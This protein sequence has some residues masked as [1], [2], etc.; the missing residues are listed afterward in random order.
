MSTW[1]VKLNRRKVV[2]TVKKVLQSWPDYS[3]GL[4]GMEILDTKGR[5]HALSSI[6]FPSYEWEKIGEGAKIE[7]TLAESL[8]NPRVISTRFISE[9]EK[10]LKREVVPVSGYIWYCEV[11][12]KRGSVDCEDVDEPRLIIRKIYE[13]HRQVSSKCDPANVQVLDKYMRKQEELTRLVA[14]EKVS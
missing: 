4:P 10:E 1:N 11:C 12:E 6:D 3:A 2:I 14:L 8:V 13:A 5:R 9:L 7:V